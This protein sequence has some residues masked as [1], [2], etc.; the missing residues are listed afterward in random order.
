MNNQTAAQMA[1]QSP[2]VLRYVYM[3]AKVLIANGS[4]TRAYKKPY[5]TFWKSRRNRN[6]AE[7]AIRQHGPEAQ[8]LVDR[9]TMSVV[10]QREQYYRQT[11]LT[12]EV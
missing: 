5:V 4:S 7:K 6:L 3:K 8:L 1:L 12:E 11:D 9:K 2:S 10:T